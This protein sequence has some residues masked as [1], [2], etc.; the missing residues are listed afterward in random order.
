MLQLKDI[1]DSMRLLNFLHHGV[2]TLGCILIQ[3]FF[4]L[5]ILDYG[6]DRL[7]ANSEVDLICLLVFL[8][9]LSISLFVSVACYYLS[10]CFILHLSR[11]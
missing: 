8:K 1:E 7:G 11:K 3:Y 2:Y 6:F 5:Q 9:I 10:F 4:V